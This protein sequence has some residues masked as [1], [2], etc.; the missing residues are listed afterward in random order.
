MEAKGLYNN[1]TEFVHKV[2]ELFASDVTL[3]V[4]VTIFHAIKLLKDSMAEV[5]ERDFL[6]SEKKALTK[7]FS[8]TI[9]HLELLQKQLS[10][11]RKSYENFTRTVNAKGE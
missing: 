6:E 9:E 10:E 1:V 7:F 2:G 4:E 3:P 11:T 5:K 8:E